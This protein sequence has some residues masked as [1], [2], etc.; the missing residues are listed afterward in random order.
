MKA[1]SRKLLFVNLV[2]LVIFVAFAAWAI[3]RLNWHA[4]GDR[5]ADASPLQLVFMAAAWVAALFARP[6]RLLILI[7]AM[8]PEVGRRYWPVWC[9]D[10]IAMAMN[11]IIPVRA[12]D[13]TMAL[14]LRHG[15]GMRAARGVSVVLVDRLFD[16]L[17]AVVL[18]GAGLSVAPSVA[19]WAANLTVTM[20][21]VFAVGATA[22]WLT[23]RLR[24]AWLALFDAALSRIAPRHRGT[25]RN[26]LHEL[27]EGLAVVNRPSVMAPVLVLSV[28]FWGAIVVSYWFGARAVWPDISLAAAA[29][30]AGAIALSFAIPTPP[31][32]FGVF[33]AVAVATFSLFGMS[34]EAALACAIICHAFQLGSVLVLG[35][36][37]LVAQGMNI[38]ALTD[39][40]PEAGKGL[41]P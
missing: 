3:A 40:N 36:V 12:G 13:M 5:L 41:T 30:T 32:G 34:A 19:P 8:A 28:V 23:I 31:A 33:H 29:F 11:S 25:W 2:A 1:V 22:L 21:I 27:L 39:V 26:R 16:L 7:G 37:A 15:L 10:L 6:L 35:P 38:R 20:P 18:F 9:A 17:M 4:V 24:A 14:V